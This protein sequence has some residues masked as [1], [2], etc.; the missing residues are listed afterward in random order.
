MKQRQIY[1]TKMINEGKIRQ[2]NGI[3]MIKN[4]RQERVKPQPSAVTSRSKLA[5]A[6]PSEGRS[7]GSKS[8]REVEAHLIYTRDRCQA[9]GA[10]E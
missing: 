4:K 5:K 6:I 8:L 3:I 2:K 10:Q 7:R 9:S 1:T